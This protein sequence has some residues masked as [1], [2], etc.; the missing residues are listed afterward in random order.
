MI[1]HIPHSGIDVLDYPVPQEQINL[2]TDWFTDELFEHQNSDR[3]VQ[4]H[5]RLIVDCERLPDDIEP[6]FARGQGIVP[7]VDFF[8]NKLSFE[9]DKEKMIAV[10]NEH[11]KNLN[12]IARKTLCCIPV[13]FVVDCH[14]FGIH[15]IAVKQ[16]DYDFC[17]GYNDD[18]DSFE[19]L[20]RMKEYIESKGFSVGIN[21]PFS[22]AI[23]PSQFYGDG[24]V[25]SIMIEVNKRMYLT[26]DFQKSDG[27]ENTKFVISNLLGMIS[28][29]EMSFDSKI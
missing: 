13:V 29:E 8:G 10:Y 12:A 6:L 2:A 20:N 5:S 24:Q 22:N 23:V 9:I 7:S 11:H 27:F 17:L 19:M 26:D 28:E 21:A 14:S 25:K 18:F 15:Q 3:V 4:S 1:F 16:Q